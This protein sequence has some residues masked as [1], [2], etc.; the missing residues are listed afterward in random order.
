MPL[1]VNVKA[2]VEQLKDAKKN[3][4]EYKA[5]FIKDIKILYDS[6]EHRKSLIGVLGIW[7]YS[8][9]T[10]YLIGYYVKYFPGDI[11]T[12]FLMMTIAEIIAP[13]TLRFVQK[14]FTTKYVS[15]YLL[16]CAAGTSVLFIV[17]DYF[18]SVTI[19]PVLILL[20]RIFVKAVYSLGYYSNGKLFPTLVKTSIFSLTNGIGRPF[21]AL[22]TMVTEYTTHPGEIFLIT[23]LAFT[24]VSFLL[25]E[26]DDTE[27][28]LEK[29]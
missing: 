23:A 5:S 21:S 2:M 27:Q 9:F 20:I 8:S 14:K 12:N 28:E 10:Y 25:P 3:S 11:F 1:D 17:N 26:S 16:L 15:R 24:G 7:I 18:G 19:I 29:I 22:S 6:P 4:V 13:I